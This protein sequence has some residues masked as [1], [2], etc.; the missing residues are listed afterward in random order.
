MYNIEELFLFNGLTCNQR[1]EIIGY[2]NDVYSFEKGNVIFDNTHFNSALGV[3]LSGKGYAGN[4]NTVKASFNEGDVFG[5]AALFGAGEEYVSR[6][7]AKTSCKVLFIKED[8]L[9]KIISE[10]PVCAVNYITFLSDK[11]RYLNEKIAQYTGDS[12]SSR[13]YRLLCEKADENGIIDNV[14]MS[15]LASLSGMG[16]TSIYRAV[17]ELEEKD[18]IKREDKKIYIRR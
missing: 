17:S 11:I 16:R 10:Y 2:F 8:T 7:V 9:R 12:A 15:L 3:F 4:G 6:I 1:K 18:I 14:N 5:A 13:L